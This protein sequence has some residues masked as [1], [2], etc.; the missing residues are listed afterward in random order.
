[1]SEFEAFLDL[2]TKKYL[3]HWVAIKGN[4]VIAHGKDFKSVLAKSK[5]KAKRRPF[6]AKIPEKA[7]MIF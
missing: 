6:I 7:T 1:M 5:E 2:D 4:E 3:G